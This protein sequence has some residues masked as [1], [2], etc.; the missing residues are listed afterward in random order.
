[1]SDLLDVVVDREKWHR[2]K[3]G[4]TSALYVPRTGKMCCLGFAALKLDLKIEDISD[5]TTPSRLKC[6]IPTGF[7]PL[8]RALEVNYDGSEFEDSDICS[9]LT[10]VNDDE[11]ILNDS[12]R[13][14]KLI[15]LGK[16]A[17]INFSFV[18]PVRK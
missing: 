1:M 18:G 11:Q 2:G 12:D 4:Y 6:D 10:N 15:E 7:L 13:E 9:Q 5:I 16:Q 17:G 3:G 8:V 14:A